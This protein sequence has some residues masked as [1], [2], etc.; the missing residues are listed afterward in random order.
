MTAPPDQQSPLLVV[1]NSLEIPS[2][3]DG[4]AHLYLDLDEAGR[5]VSTLK[6]EAATRLG[7]LMPS[8]TAS[9]SGATFERSR[10]AKRT[11]WQ[12]EDLLRAV[13]DSRYV[14]QQT[15]EVRDESQLDKVLDVFPLGTPR[16]TALRARGFD[17]DEWCDEAWN[18]GWTIQIWKGK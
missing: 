4:L 18:E 3:F 17:P 14:S 12:K 15:G 1:L 7:D 10:S 13:L 6:R 5:I 2:D 11:A 8:K 9:V 16:V